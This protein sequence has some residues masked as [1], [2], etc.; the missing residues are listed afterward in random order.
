[1]IDPRRAL[2]STLKKWGHDI[3]LQRRLNDDMLYST[4]LQKYTTRRYNAQMANQTNA[5]QEV[6]EGLIVNSEMVYFFEHDVNPKSGDRIYEK[7]PTGEQVFLIDQAV[8]FMGKHGL[9]VYWAVGATRE[10]PV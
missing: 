7:Y 9:V 6:P 4:R 3:L 10:L 8:P 1:M 5:A 2:R